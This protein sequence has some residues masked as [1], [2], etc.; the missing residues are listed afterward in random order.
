MIMSSSGQPSSVFIVCADLSAE[1]YAWHFIQSLPQK[2]KH[3]DAIGGDYLK[4]RGVKIWKNNQDLS[5]IG[6]IQFFSK[7]PYI[8]LTLIRTIQFIKK[9]QPDLLLLVD[10]G[11]FNIRLIRHTKHLNIP[12]YYLMPPRM[13]VHQIPS[14]LNL[15]LIHYYDFEKDQLAGMTALQVAHPKAGLITAQPAAK[16]P[17]KKLALFPGSRRF[18]LKQL[19]PILETLRQTTDLEVTYYLQQPHNQKLAQSLGVPPKMIQDTSPE[20][21][22]ADFA[23]CASGTITLEM[24]LRNIPMICIYKVGTFDYQLIKRFVTVKH[25]ALPNLILNEKFVPELIQHECDHKTIK[26]ELDSISQEAVNRQL[27]GFQKIRTALTKNPS[28][29]S[30][31]AQKGSMVEKC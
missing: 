26:H 2:P 9:T 11:A 6:F 23:I 17:F 8:L 27:L 1:A 13:S 14:G 4:T 5:A 24:A 28:L 12:T 21:I 19:I 31:L 10:A 3:I 18:E 25:I 16:F 15:R 7:L 20:N 29:Q 22:E 30:L